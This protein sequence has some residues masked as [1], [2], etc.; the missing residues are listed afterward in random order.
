[1]QVE[2][3]GGRR[4]VGS[5]LRE[6]GVVNEEE[7]E[8]ALVHQGERGGR[9]G[10]I[11]LGWGLVSGPTLTRVLADQ[12]GEQLDEESGFGTGLRGEI[13]RRQREQARGRL[14]LAARQVATTTGGL[15]DV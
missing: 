14:A 3:R 13:E 6:Q 2:E 9:L 12:R 11:L 1:M 10:E 8:R 15:G 7:V 4:P 5:L